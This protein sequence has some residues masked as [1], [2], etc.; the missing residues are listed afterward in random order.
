MKSLILLVGLSVCWSSVAAQNSQHSEHRFYMT[1]NGQKMKATDFDQWMQQ[2]G[3]H[4]VPQRG[5]RI[6]QASARPSV[7]SSSQMPTVLYQPPQAYTPASPT[8]TIYQGPSTQQLF[9]NSNSDPRIQSASPGSI[10]GF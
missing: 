4:I 5:Q 1:D 3:V 6:A 2:R 10:I 9:Q 7:G 8:G